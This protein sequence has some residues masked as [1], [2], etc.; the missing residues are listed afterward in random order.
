MDF[1]AWEGRLWSG[2][3]KA[4]LDAWANDFLYAQPHGGESVAMLC[5]R[6][7]EAKCEFLSYNETILIITHAGV[8][9]AAFAHGDE[10]EYFETTVG[11]GCSKTLSPERE[12]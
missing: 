9:K 6:V 2:L 11:F 12:T 8:I 5:E 1:G 4:E 7:R 10:P 3:P